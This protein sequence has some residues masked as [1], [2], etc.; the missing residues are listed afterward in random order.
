M[1]STTYFQTGP[2][3]ILCQIV[4]LDPK[5][6]PYPQDSQD[7]WDRNHV[8]LPC[9]A[10]RPSLSSSTGSVDWSEIVQGL[11]TR[12][13]NSLELS[14]MMALWNEGDDT[15]RN[16]RALDA[17][18]N[19]KADRQ[20]SEQFSNR[21]CNG[22]DSPLA[23]LED[24]EPDEKDQDE[25]DT[26]QNPDCDVGMKSSPEDVSM[27][28]YDHNIDAAE[29]QFLNREER[30]RFFNEILP[31]MQGLAL[32]LPDLI[33]KPIPFLREQEDSAI[34]LSQEQAP[35]QYGKATEKP[36]EVTLV[37]SPLQGEELRQNNS[38]IDNDSSHHG[39]STGDREDSGDSGRNESGRKESFARYPSINFSSLFCSS[40]TAEPCT[41]ANA[42]KLRCILHYFDRVTSHMPEGTVT[43]HRQVLKKTITLAK[44]ERVSKN[45]FRY[46]QVRVDPDSP[47]EDDAPIGALQLDFANKAIGG[48]VLGRGSV[49]EEIRFVICPELIVSRLF[50][51]QMQDNEAVLIKGAERYSNYNG[52]ART[53]AWHS[54][55]VDNTPRD[56]LGRRK[57]EICAIDAY[58]FRT[59]TNDQRLDQ[60]SEEYVLRELNKAI[61]GF[62]RSPITSSEWGLCR[63]EALSDDTPQ[64]AT[65]N[66]GCGAFGG[67]LQLKFLIQLLAASICDGYSRDD[68]NDG[69]PLGRDLIYYTYGLDELGQDIACFMSQ[70]LA[71]PKVFEPVY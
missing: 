40:D 33:K 28:S 10:Q 61:V 43:Y 18:L 41:S 59:K 19:N 29:D 38:N 2:H 36:R 31:R 51:Q 56:K 66:W 57:T 13:T 16:T 22:Y 37:K 20:L 68:I 39:N 27:E 9:S 60:F 7:S 30:D 17:F 49:Q 14:E 23:G 62:R 44:D 15:T 70:L 1:A 46:V 24:P 63:A 47:L 35:V 71:S 64:I 50:T 4:G 42:A 21:N 55:H 52:Y 12:V 34:T 65:G 25:Q 58:P 26:N 53:F 45:S 32:R 67:H 48:G 54:D 3:H 8:R 11:T 5:E 69:I 6:F